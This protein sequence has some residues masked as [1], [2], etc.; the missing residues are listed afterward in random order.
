[1]AGIICLGIY[2]SI[3]VFYCLFLLTANR[4]IKDRQMPRSSPETRFCILI[5]AH[6]EELLLPRLLKSLKKQDYPPELLDMLVIADNCSD[7]TPQVAY[8]FNAIVLERNDNERIGKGFAIKFALDNIDLNQYDVIFI[9]DADSILQSD[10]LTNLDQA[11]RNG[12]KIMQCYNGVANP[13]DSWFTRLMNVS[14]TIGNEIFEPAKE[15]LHLSSHLMGNG[16]CFHKDIIS[17]YG[18]SAFSVG[19]DWEYYANLIKDGERIAFAKNVRVFH[20]ESSSLR[21]ATPQRVRWSSGRFQIARKYGFGLLYRGFSE[22]SFTKISASFPLIFPN[23][24]L[25]MNITVIGL[26]LCLLLPTMTGKNVLVLWFCSLTL[27]HF[28]IFI[29]GIMYTKKRL[30]NSLSLFFAAPFLIWKLGIDIFS[31]LGMGK[32]KWIRTERKL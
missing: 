20:Q 25:G 28:F 12:N 2:I 14:R 10:A 16:M 18:W 19:E 31:A 15:K 3:Y 32:K 22:K 24:S 6:D 13:D 30:K 17:K 23:P 21:Q 5:P 7:K 9:I 11:V 26:I 29:A 4:V 1:M 8:A 27:V